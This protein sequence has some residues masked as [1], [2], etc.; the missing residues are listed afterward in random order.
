MKGEVLERRSRTPLPIRGHLRRGK[1]KLFAVR[2]RCD[3]RVVPVLERHGKAVDLSPG[4]AVR[5]DDEERLLAQEPDQAQRWSDADEL[6]EPLQG[7]LCGVGDPGAADEAFQQPYARPQQRVV[8]CAFVDGDADARNTRVR[9]PDP[10]T[11]PSA[12]RADGEQGG[13]WRPP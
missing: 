12:R 4:Q 5:A 7:E 3:E 9:R 13:L 2:E 1:E 6:A 10:P 11:R 8:A